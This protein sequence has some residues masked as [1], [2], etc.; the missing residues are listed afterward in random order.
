MIRSLHLQ[1]FQMLL[2]GLHF[3]KTLTTLGI[4]Y[5]RDPLLQN[6]TKIGFLT[7]D[8]FNYKAL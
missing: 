2:E 7:L 6:V 1:R 3:V 4:I 8:I 5:A